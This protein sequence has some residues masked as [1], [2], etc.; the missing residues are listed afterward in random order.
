M[1]PE[2]EK[3]AL[4]MQKLAMVYLPLAYLLGKRKAEKKYGIKQKW[5]DKDNVNVEIL[6]NR[7]AEELSGSMA[8]IEKQVSEGKPVEGLIDNLISRAGSWAWVLSPALAMGL[9]AYVDDNRTEIGKIENLNSN[10]IGIIWYTAEDSRVCKICSYLAG[11]WFDAKQAYDLAAKVH[12]GCR[13]PAHF[14][15]GTPDEALSGPIPDYK[16]GTAQDI[17]RDLNISGLVQA[18]EKRAR[19]IVSRGKPANYARPV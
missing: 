12:P 3:L 4:E 17:Y 10:N 6:L 11:R 8:T 7:H 1:R 9:S 15:V 16:P 2:L 5:S 14:D 19:D 18:R 13:C